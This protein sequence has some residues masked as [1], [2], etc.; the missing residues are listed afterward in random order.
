MKTELI[1]LNAA[2][3]KLDKDW[4][5]LAVVLPLIV[6]QGLVLP[7]VQRL[8]KQIARLKKIRD[9]FLRIK[10][11]KPPA[12]PPGTSGSAAEF[13]LRAETAGIRLRAETYGVSHG[14]HVKAE[15]SGVPTG[16]IFSHSRR[17][18]RTAQNFTWHCPNGSPTKMWYF[19]EVLG[20]DG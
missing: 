5:Y 12:A 1:T 8:L 13:L 16:Y 15:S 10:Q 11:E 2:L 4:Y 19:E 14:I 6:E 7:H 17:H 18:R 9:D 20:R 3:K